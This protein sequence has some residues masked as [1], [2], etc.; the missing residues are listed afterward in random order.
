VHPSAMMR[1]NTSPSGFPSYR[2]YAAVDVA[3]IGGGGSGA[4]GHI[5]DALLTVGIRA[6]IIV[7]ELRLPG[8]R[9][10][11][12]PAGGTICFQRGSSRVRPQQNAATA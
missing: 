3:L 11:R 9:L 7:E 6:R 12:R 5:D 2:P 1:R 8:A 4:Q 10:V